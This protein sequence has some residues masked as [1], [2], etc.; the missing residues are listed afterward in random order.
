MIY[1]S[2]RSR[3]TNKQQTNKPSKGIAASYQILM[4]QFII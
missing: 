4:A 2:E 3:K 1:A